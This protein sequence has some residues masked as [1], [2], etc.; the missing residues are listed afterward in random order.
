MEIRRQAARILL[1]VAVVNGLATVLCLANQTGGRQLQV[2]TLLCPF[3]CL[4]CR[5]KKGRN[6]ILLDSYRNDE[7]HEV[8]AGWMKG[9]DWGSNRS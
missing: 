7:S 8:G 5:E 2:R 9:I 4:S 1:E 3:N 6:T